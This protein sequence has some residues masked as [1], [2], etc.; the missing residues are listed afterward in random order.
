MQSQ[1]SKR[2]GLLF[3][4]F[5]PIHIGHLFMGEMVLD[6][7]LVEE[8]WYVVSPA[9]PYKI[10]SGTLAP[11]MDRL[12]MV[13]ASCKCNDK[14]KACAIEFEP[15]FAQPSYT[16]ITLDVLKERHPDHEFHMICGTDVYVD[17]PNWIGGDKVI[18]ACNFIVYPRNSTTNYTPLDMALK[19]TFLNGVPNLEISATFL[20][21]QIKKGGVIR[22]LM[23]ETAIEFTKKYN[24]YK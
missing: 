15:T 9:S 6:R 10:D 2:I 18:D 19:T 3:G 20:R 8:V 22:H 5:N 16:Y 13:T 11:A 23:P 4:S 12:A 14:F 17:I 7:G 21:D 1:K 24:L